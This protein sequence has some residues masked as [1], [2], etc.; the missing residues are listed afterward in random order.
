[1]P[2]FARRLKFEHISNPKTWQHGKTYTTD[3]TFPV[4]SNKH[5]TSY[6]KKK[7]QMHLDID[8]RD[9]TQEQLQLLI[10]KDR[11]KLWGH[12]LLSKNK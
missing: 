9:P 6:R 11:Q 7:T 4:G 12:N 1:M 3:T 5:K 8:L 10:I 2:T